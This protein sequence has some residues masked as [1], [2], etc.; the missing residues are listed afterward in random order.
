VAGT[1][2]LDAFE[3]LAAKQNAFAACIEFL[4]IEG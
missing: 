4:K 3:A 2:F 1:S